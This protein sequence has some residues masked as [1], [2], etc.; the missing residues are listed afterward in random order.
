MV[1][2][3]HNLTERARDVLFYAKYYSSPDKP[4]PVKAEHILLAMLLVDPRLFQLLSGQE[5]DEVLANLKHELKAFDP[6]IRKSWQATEPPPLSAEAE[7]IIALAVEES[8]RLGHSRTGT[9][10]LLLG[11]VKT[12]VSEP[13]A[14]SEPSEAGKILR[15]RGFSVESVTSQLQT[16]SL[17]PQS[18]QGYRSSMIGE[19]PRSSLRPPRRLFRFM[20]RAFRRLRG[21]FAI[22]LMLCGSSPAQFIELSDRRYGGSTE[23]S[24]R[25]EPVTY[26]ALGDSTG[27]GLGAKNGYGYV[28]QLMARIQ[29]E[30]PGSRLLK[31][32]RLG[33][34]TTGL[35]HRV[36]EGFTVKPTVVTL[37]IG[38]NDLLQRVTDEQFAANYEE[39]V[40]SL[41]HLA[42]PIVVTN[43]PD[44]SFAPKLPN[45]MREE[46]HVQVLLFNHRIETIA[47]Q[48]A[49]LFVDLYQASRKVI[50]THPGFFSSDGFHPSDAGYELWSRTMWSAMK[51]AVNRT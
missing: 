22:L 31:M 50:A 32:C 36:T 26:L 34:T 42:V 39:I 33:E 15:A 46:I 21:P 27:L 14:E 11:L 30:H 25:A 10:H 5:S 12:Q 29:N 43:L 3:E 49:L 48:Y 44:I 16:G 24:G 41:K 45:A 38:I 18:G 51:K 2:E 4:R 1:I 47:K 7:Q 9:E 28:E 37:S 19:L 23:R 8:K 20:T 35:R 17:T 13:G 40:K 6:A